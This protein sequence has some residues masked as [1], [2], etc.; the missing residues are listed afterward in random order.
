MFCL[1]NYEILHHNQDFFVCVPM[2]LEQILTTEWT[3]LWHSIKGWKPS[4]KYWPSEKWYNFIEGRV[5]I[6]SVRTNKLPPLLQFLHSSQ[7]SSDHGQEARESLLVRDYPKPSENSR[8]SAEIIQRGNENTRKFPKSRNLSKI[9]PEILRRLS[10]IPP[11]FET[12]YQKSESHCVTNIA[13]QS[14]RT[15][16]MASRCYKEMYGI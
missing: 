9:S 10:S 14:N 1:D 16:K 7:F 5:P 6:V 8:T 12:H 11:I 13:R 15:L 3:N 4:K 2:I